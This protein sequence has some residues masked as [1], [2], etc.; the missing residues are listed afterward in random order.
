M[1]INNNQISP[2]F[3][4]ALRLD[5]LCENGKSK[6]NKCFSKTYHYL[7]LH[8]TSVSQVDN[9]YDI[10]VSLLKKGSKKVKAQIM[11]PANNSEASVVLATVYPRKSLLG[12][13]D[14][15]MSVITRACEKANEFN[16]VV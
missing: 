2:Q 14:E 16:S 8:K 5:T 1:L 13:A 12:R 10:V 3:G 11:K 4:M 7:D 15:N 9:P 6:L